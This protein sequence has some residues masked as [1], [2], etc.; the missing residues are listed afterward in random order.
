MTI[1]G[2]HYL[3]RELY[4]LVQNERTI[5]D[6]LQES[7]L[8]GLWYWDLEAPE[9]EWLS[10]R[11]WQ[12]LG[13][14]PADKKHLA[15]EWQDLINPDDLQTALKNFRA[16]CADPKHP[17]EQLVRYKHA[18]GSTVWV[19]CR[20]L[21]IRDASGKPIRMLGAHNEVTELKRVEAKLEQQADEL[22]TANAN[23]TRLVIR[24]GLT[25]LFN[26]HAFDGHL[27]WSLAN[28]VRRKERLSVML[29]DLDHF[30]KIN[31]TLGHSKGDD[32]LVAAAAALQ[33][34]VRGND[35]AARYG[36]EE[37]SVVLPQADPSASLTVAEKVRARIAQ[38]DTHDCSVTASIGVATVTAA[39]KEP[40]NNIKTLA[41]TLLFQ[42]DRAL[43]EAKRRGRNQVCHFEQM[44]IAP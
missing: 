39:L 27:E 1:K 13:Y 38:A 9:N 3:K 32:V 43:Y 7:S 23:L 6:F 5:F 24:D 28:A 42:A 19:R 20:G 40:T 29:V 21:A 35:Y 41:S 34:T 8:D 2:D 25:N 16:H 26:R 31:D 12:I 36:G 15:N 44:I 17:Y 4:A 11:F 30:K 37:F 14:D 22:K 10:P 18:D 33:A